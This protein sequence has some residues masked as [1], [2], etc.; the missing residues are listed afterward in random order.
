MSAGAGV[1][2]AL[3]L[4]IVGAGGGVVWAQRNSAAA[5]AQAVSDKNVCLSAVQTTRTTLQQL[6]E[7][8]A[9]LQARHEAMTRL[10]TAELNARQAQIDQLNAAAAERQTVIVEKA[11][12]PDCADLARLPLCPAIADQLWPPAAQTAG[13]D[14]S[15]NP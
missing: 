14:A 13:R 10:G 1:A 11:R 2:I 7:K 4:F 12:E 6:D 3:L 8:Y 5:I 15:R 9:A